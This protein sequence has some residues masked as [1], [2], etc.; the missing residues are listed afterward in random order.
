[1]LTRGMH[2]WVAP[3]RVVRLHSP[4]AQNLLQSAGMAG[5]GKRRV[6]TSGLQIEVK[7]GAPHEG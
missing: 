6:H 4:V 7:G 2:N 1:V 3:E 5:M